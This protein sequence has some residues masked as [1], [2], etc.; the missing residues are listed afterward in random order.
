MTVYKGAAEH[1]QSVWVAVRGS[2]RQVLEQVTLEDVVQG[3]LPD[4][5]SALTQT[6]DAWNPRL[7]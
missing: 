2:L 1:L 6:P 5:V 4:S 7:R 3:R